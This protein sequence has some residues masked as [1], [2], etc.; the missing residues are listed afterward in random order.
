MASILKPKAFYSTTQIAELLQLKQ[1]TI[2]RWVDDGQLKAYRFGRKYRI[3]GEDFDQFMQRYKAHTPTP[4][5][6][7][8][9]VSADELVGLELP[10]E[11][12]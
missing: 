10:E 6:A 1:R 12:T 11:A 8:G 5:R 7:P 3:Q 4:Q 9:P 2:Q